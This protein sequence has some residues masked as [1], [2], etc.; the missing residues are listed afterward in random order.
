[1]SC[2]DISDEVHQLESP[3]SCAIL[4]KFEREGRY[5][6]G[7]I[8]RGNHF[9]ELQRCVDSDELWVTIHT[10]SRCM[11]PAIRDYF[12]SIA[13]GK[14]KGLFYLVAES[15]TGKLYMAE[16]SWARKYANFNRQLIFTRFARMLKGIIDIDPDIKRAVHGDHNHVESI[17]LKGKAMLVHRKGANSA[18]KGEL[19]IIPGSMGSATFHCKGKGNPESLYSS[20]HGAGRCMSRQ[21][22][23]KTVT[24]ANLAQ[25]LQGVFYQPEKLSR[26]TQES[27]SAYKNI[28]TVM[29][30]QKKLVAT[31][32][33]LE[34]VL[35]YK[36]V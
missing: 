20:S 32:R 6:L 29:K 3:S 26:L 14:S 21:R 8:G 34:P 22:A 7:T 4:K 36:G 35:N 16:H 33:R 18:R 31:V 1:M 9:L 11:G 10:G 15:E 13:T 12:N 23:S 25:Q 19:A 27:P 24:R 2:K 5:Q 28:A 17:L 30:Q